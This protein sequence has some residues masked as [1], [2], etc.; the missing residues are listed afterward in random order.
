MNKSKKRPE[1][2]QAPRLLV[3]NEYC[4]APVSR[5]KTAG[6]H[7]LALRLVPALATL[8]FAF[9]ANA[10]SPKPDPALV[11]LSTGSIPY[12]ITS[13]GALVR[14]GYTQCVRTGYWSL[15]AAKTAKMKD[16]G[17]PVGCYCE[18]ELLP[19]EVCSPPPPAPVAAPAPA[20]RAEPAPVTPPPPVLTPVPS[21][22]KVNIPSDA[23][24]AYDKAEIS[25]IGRDKLTDFSNRIKN[26]NL[27]V[28]TAVGHADR[29]GSDSYNQKL[30]EKRA[31]SV[32]DFLIS[33]GIPANRVYT[34][35]K[36][37]TQPV[38]G[39]TCKHIGPENRRNRKLIDCLG[40]DRRVELEAVG[41]RT[42]TK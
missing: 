3:D 22:E 9:G 37:K 8:T 41:T 12:V 34:E 15:E 29:I 30:S 28:I 32:K 2:S 13:S 40:P 10:Q 4:G 5:I 18:P 11:N 21:A 7:S 19:T 31:N 25:D 6:H 23:L 24:F 33:Q 26:I 16:T 1:Q 17:K 20:P 14:G 36:G 35:G 27:E 38:T 42:P 39:D